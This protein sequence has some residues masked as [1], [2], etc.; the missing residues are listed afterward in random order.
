[1]KEKALNGDGCKH[2][3]HREITSVSVQGASART[4]GNRYKEEELGGR[5][6]KGLSW[7]KGKL[8]RKTVAHIK[9]TKRM[10]ASACRALPSNNRLIIH[11]GRVV[12]DSIVA[13]GRL[14]RETIAAHTECMDGTRASACRAHQLEQQLKL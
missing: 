11:E 14:E 7:L 3:L 8:E 5:Y 9:C 1:M 2:K 4:T 10:C 6:K 12:G 13:G